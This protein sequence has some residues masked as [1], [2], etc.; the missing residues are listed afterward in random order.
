M[1]FEKKCFI[2]TSDILAVRYE[3]SKCHVAFTVPIAQLDPNEAA[4]F[5]N[6]KCAYCQEPSGFA[7]NTQEIRTLLGFITA[8]KNISGTMVGRNLKLRLDIKCGE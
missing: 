4:S 1:T 7:P 8:L 6:T 3:C 5:A 2:E